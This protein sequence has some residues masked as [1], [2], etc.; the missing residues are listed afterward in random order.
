MC[1]FA[2]IWHGSCIPK[3][4]AAHSCSSRA[5]DSAQRRGFV[6]QVVQNLNPFEECGLTVVVLISADK[7]YLEKKKNHI[8]KN[9]R[10]LAWLLCVTVLSPL[11]SQSV[12]VL[13]IHFIAPVRNSLQSISILFLTSVVL[14]HSS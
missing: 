12:L 6:R 11:T 5:G 7:S 14:F 2:G 13:P 3:L 8:Q 1:Q 9:G 10:W 4:G